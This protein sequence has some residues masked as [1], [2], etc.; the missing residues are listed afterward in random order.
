MGIEHRVHARCGG[1]HE[2]VAG[3]KP[4][5]FA[6]SPR[7]FERDRPFSLEHLALDLT[8]DFEHRSV[9]GTATLDVKRVDPDADKLVLDAVAFLIEKVTLEGKPTPHAYDGKRIEITIPPS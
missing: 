1:F 6:S 7:H 3:Q 2:H 8:L 9:R 4:F 5:A